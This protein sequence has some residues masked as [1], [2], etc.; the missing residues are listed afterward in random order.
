MAPGPGT[1][2]ALQAAGVPD[3]QIDAPAPD[4]TQFDS[5]ALWQV[6]GQRDW[7]G[8]RV[9]VVRGHSAG[10]QGASSGRDW[11]A[12]QWQQAGAQVDFVGVYQRQAP[13]LDAAQLQ[14]VYAASGDGSVWLFSSSEALV[15]LLG[16]AGLDGVDWRGARAVA[17]HPRIEAAVRAAGWGVVAPSR[18]ALHDIGVTLASLEST[19]P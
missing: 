14:R 6:I 7:R 16:L 5:E 10:A 11:I 9:L 12:R 1:V 18:P 19:H 15:N 3:A 8:R 2:A 13:L 17:T 4:A